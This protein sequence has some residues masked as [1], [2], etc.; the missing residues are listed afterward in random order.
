MQN[1]GRM[2][3]EWTMK[4]E[5]GWGMNDEGRWFQAHEGFWWWTN[6]QTDI[7]DCR[8]GF[9]TEKRHLYHITLINYVL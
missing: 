2:K 8:V 9:T 7:C 6:R 5:E 1:E 4:S 3:D